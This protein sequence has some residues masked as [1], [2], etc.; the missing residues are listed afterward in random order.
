MTRSESLGQRIGAILALYGI[1]PRRTAAMLK[2]TPG[3]IRDCIAFARL[4]RSSREWRYGSFYPHLLD[5]HAAAGQARGDYFHQDLLVARRI[6]ARNPVRHVDVGSRID[7]FVAHVA[8]FRQIGVS[9]HIRPMTGPVPNIDFMQ[10]DLT[11]PL[12]PDCVDVNLL[13][14]K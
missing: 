4:N 5:R 7:G 14:L 2:R 3:F 11:E 10:M 13:K 9:L 8:A 6:F 1:A 12:A